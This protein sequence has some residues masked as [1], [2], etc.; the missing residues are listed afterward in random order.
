MSSG[1]SKFVLWTVSPRDHFVVGDLMGE[2]A[3]EHAD[4]AVAEGAE[5]L[6]MPLPASSA[7]VVVGPGS[8]GGIERCESPQIDGVGQASVADVAG[9]DGFLSARRPGDGRR[10]GVILA[11]LRGGIAVRLVAE[12]AEHPGAEDGP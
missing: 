12:L 8:G 10:A 1:Q 3:V 11:T 2:A 7:G 4:Q 5:G 9:Q 6:V